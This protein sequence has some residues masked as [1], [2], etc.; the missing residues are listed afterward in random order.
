MPSRITSH[1]LATLL[2]ELASALRQMS[3]VPLSDLQ[4]P[5]TRTA[6]PTVDI[7]GLAETIPHLDKDEMSE[8]LNALRQRHLIQLCRLLK[9]SVG[10]KRTKP[11]LVK[12]ILWHF[13]GAKDDLERIRTFEEK[14][15]Q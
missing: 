13:F 5:R 3:D 11:A 1:Q 12:Q 2:E 15:E 14:S 7:S 4:P 6:K 10:S 8:R 9:V